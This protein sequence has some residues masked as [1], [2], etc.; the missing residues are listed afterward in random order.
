MD[1]ILLFLDIES[2]LHCM[3]YLLCQGKGGFSNE[4]EKT[5]IHFYTNSNDS[6]IKIIK[7]ENVKRIVLANAWFFPYNKI[8]REVFLWSE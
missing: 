5:G 7:V 3:V 4:T 8:I 2:T 6:I 1:K